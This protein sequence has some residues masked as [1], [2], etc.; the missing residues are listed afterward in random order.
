MGKVRLGDKFPDPTAIG[1]GLQR[2]KDFTLT[3]QAMDKDELNRCKIR[4]LISMNTIMILKDLSNMTRK[5]SLRTSRRF[6]QSIKQLIKSLYNFWSCPM[7]S[8]NRGIE[9]L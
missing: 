8:G 6:S 9:R 4:E 7:N 2:L 5:N 3:A 1:I